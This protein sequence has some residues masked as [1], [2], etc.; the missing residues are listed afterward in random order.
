MEP[1]KSTLINKNNVFY[2]FFGLLEDYISNNNKKLTLH[3]YIDQT[4]TTLSRKL[5][6]NLLKMQFVTC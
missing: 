5:T 6:C 3:S 2:E 4:I 1:Q